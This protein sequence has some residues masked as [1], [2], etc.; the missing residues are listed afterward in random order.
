MTASLQRVTNKFR[1]SF[2]C[3]R[4]QQYDNNNIVSKTSPFAEKKKCAA[5]FVHIHTY[6]H[7][8]I[9]TYIILCVRVCKFGGYTRF[10][11]DDLVT[12]ALGHNNDIAP[13]VSGSLALAYK[14]IN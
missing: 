14:R 6:I 10:A 12:T 3:V 5:A 7:S 1:S 11:G 8:Y 9:H 13:A 2:H 4:A